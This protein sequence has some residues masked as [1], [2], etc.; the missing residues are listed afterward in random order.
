MVKIPKED[1]LSYHA[2]FAS[3]SGEDWFL[4]GLIGSVFLQKG[5]Q[6][7]LQRYLPENTSFQV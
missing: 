4:L 7:K 3:H 5:L 1:F 2:K 6:G